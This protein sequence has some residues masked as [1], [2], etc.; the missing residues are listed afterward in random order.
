MSHTRTSYLRVPSGRVGHLIGPRGSVIQDLSRRTG[1][2]IHISR[3]IIDG[4]QEAS[5]TGTNAQ[6]ASAEELIRAT[7]QSKHDST[8]R[9][10]TS[11]QA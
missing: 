2:R 11:H 8:S 4:S 7:I 1:T 6:I 9:R 3:V 10:R 5:I